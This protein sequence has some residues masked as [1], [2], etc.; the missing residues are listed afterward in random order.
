MKMIEIIAHPS[1]KL[2]RV[3]TDLLGLVHIYTKE[4]AQ[5][6]LANRAIKKSLAKYLDIKE[7]QLNLIAGAQ[8][9]YKRFKITTA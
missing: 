3:E 4:P 6:G 5:D 7:S 2:P 1:S 9:K 8:S